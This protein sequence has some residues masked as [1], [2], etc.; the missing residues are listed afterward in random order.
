MTD[1]RLLLG[2]AVVVRGLM[3]DEGWAFFA[4]FVIET[5]PKRGHPPRDYRLVLDGVFW[6]ARTG[7]AWRDL[8]DHFG[9]W[10]SVYRQFRR[11]TLSGIWDVMLAAL[12]ERRRSRQCPD[13]RLDQRA[14]SSACRQRPKKERPALKVK[15]LAALEVAS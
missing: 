10:G 15:V 13:D 2:R 5:G 14:R 8:H 12:N 6:L 11:W 4:P 3:S 7:S 9:K 1:S